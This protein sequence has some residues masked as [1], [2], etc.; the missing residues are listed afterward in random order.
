MESA[1]IPSMSQVLWGKCQVVQKGFAGP[2][3]G[4]Q[5]GRWGK[6]VIEAKEGSAGRYPRGGARDQLPSV[7]GLK[8]LWSGCIEKPIALP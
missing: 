8:G 7:F 5:R 1:Y 4:N 2:K 3:S 6:K